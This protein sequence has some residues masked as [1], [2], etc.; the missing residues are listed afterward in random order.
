MFIMA[1]LERAP[2]A[3]LRGFM[4]VDQSLAKKTPDEAVD[5]ADNLGYFV[6]YVAPE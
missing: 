2:H 5:N 3:G 4:P 6:Y 1:R